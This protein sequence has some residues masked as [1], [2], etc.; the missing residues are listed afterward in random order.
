MPVPAMD[1]RVAA[2]ERAA[3]PA[4]SGGR[5]LAELSRQLVRLMRRDVGRGPTRAQSHWAGPNTLVTIFGDGFLRSEKTLF[6]HR[7]DG[8]AMAYRG[9]IQGTLREAMRDEVERTMGRTVIA[10]MG[11]AHH[12][13]DLIVEL[14]VFEPENGRSGGDRFAGGDAGVLPASPH[15][16]SA[17]GTPR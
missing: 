3:A 11:C 15:L 17:D 8:V 9:A 6:S 14:F 13:P 1:G 12:D 5:R 7:R 10:A 16:P 2:P 4:G